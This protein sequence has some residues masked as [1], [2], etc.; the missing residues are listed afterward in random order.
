[1]IDEKGFLKITDFGL[2]KQTSVSD[3]ISGTPEYLSPEIINN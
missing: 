2:S 3:S 1:L